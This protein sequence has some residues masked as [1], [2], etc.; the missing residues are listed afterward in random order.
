LATPYSRLAAVFYENR[1]ISM[2][3]HYKDMFGAIRHIL[4]QIDMT[5]VCTYNISLKQIEEYSEDVTKDYIFVS[6]WFSPRVTARKEREKLDI[7][8]DSTVFVFRV[9]EI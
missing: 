5:V 7:I 4:I 6:L 1:N 8:I 9:K 3:I 2:T